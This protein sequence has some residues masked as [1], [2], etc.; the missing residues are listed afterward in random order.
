MI[1]PFYTPTDPITA[2]RKPTKD[3]FIGHRNCIGENGAFQRYWPRKADYA[4]ERLT[5]GSRHKSIRNSAGL[6]DC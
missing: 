3:N 2:H 5:P 4:E 1:S 6:L